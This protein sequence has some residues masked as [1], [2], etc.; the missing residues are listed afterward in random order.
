ML[1]C[2][3]TTDRIG[4][5]NVVDFKTMIDS[6]IPIDGYHCVDPVLHPDVFEQ[7]E[8]GLWEPKWMEGWENLPTFTYTPEAGFE[9]FDPYNCTG[10]K[11][12]WRRERVLQ[13]A[14]E[15]R[16]K[17]GTELKVLRKALEAITRR[18]PELDEEPEIQALHGL[19]EHIQAR[20]AEHA[21]ERMDQEI[22]LHK[23]NG[24]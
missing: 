24:I 19:T 20:I 8:D 17:K 4:P 2:F 22:D 1:F 5:P 3:K 11:R 14:I 23:E 7:N 10:L 15:T 9:P 16:V 18:F 21:K 12:W 13:P 6:D